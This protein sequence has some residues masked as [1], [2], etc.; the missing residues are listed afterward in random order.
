M[1]MRTLVLLLLGTAVATAGP[2]IEV[3]DL[4]VI[5]QTFT[6]PG[7][8][9]NSDG[10][11]ANIETFRVVAASPLLTAQLNLLIAS[12]GESSGVIDRHRIHGDTSRVGQ[13]TCTIGFATS[14][15]VSWLCR[16]HWTMFER[17]GGGPGG[18]MSMTAE[19]Y[20]ITDGKLEPATMA[21]ILAPDK[22]GK[23]AAL[24]GPGDC[25]PNP[26]ART[27]SIGPDGIDFND[28]DLA[29]G[30]VV[31]WELLTPLLP[32][33]SP[34]PAV[35]AHEVDPKPK[36]PSAGWAKVS[37]RFTVQGETVRDKLTN[38]EW[39]TH[40][41]GAD[42]NYADAKAF[43][44]AYRGG[45]K[46]DWRLPTEAELEALSESAGPEHR[47]KT[48]CTKGKSQLMV[49]ELIHLSCGIAWSDDGFD[50]ARG[51]AFGF[52]SGTPRIAKLTEKKNSRALPVRNEPPPPKPAKNKSVTGAPPPVTP[53]PPQNLDFA[54]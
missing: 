54:K 46:T 10:S 39:A 6:V 38:L 53:K 30:C 16:G 9:G 37:D 47:E 42:I 15:F 21:K 43:A 27:I 35:I 14:V 1:G 45:G 23:L 11:V 50:D 36:D 3:R 52:I 17:S 19:A 33:K 44:K 40:D 24:S 31:S 32:A 51:I 20:F 18:S 7:E 8:N 25:H 26:E 22:L 29:T 2:A 5:P 13:Q 28:G 12:D 41:N 49:S 4:P 48:D 34:L